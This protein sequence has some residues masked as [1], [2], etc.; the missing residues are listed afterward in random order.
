MD[1][2]IDVQFPQARRAISCVTWLPKSMMSSFWCWDMAVGLGK[3]TAARKSIDRWQHWRLFLAFRP[4][5]Q[6]GPTEVAMRHTL[7]LF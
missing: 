1:L 4:A 2:A 3:G 7:L 6:N 5:I